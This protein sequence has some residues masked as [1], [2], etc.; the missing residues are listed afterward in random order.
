MP[1]N[2]AGTMKKSKIQDT[3]K[4]A[5][6]SPHTAKPPRGNQ[7]KVVAPLSGTP[8]GQKRPAPP[9]DDGPRKKKTKPAQDGP[10]SNSTQGDDTT[11]RDSDT[12][13]DKLGAVK[14]RIRSD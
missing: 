12:L 7:A 6:V 10:S 2:S 8:P 11:P 4:A 9:H 3:R 5:P 13:D 1:K 14:T